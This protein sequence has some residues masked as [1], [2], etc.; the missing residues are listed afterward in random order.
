MVKIE[1]DINKTE[2]EVVHQLLNTCNSI[3]LKEAFEQIGAD[4]SRKEIEDAME[5]MEEKWNEVHQNVV[6]GK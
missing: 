3:Q 5:S 1:L 4:E 6:R 2:W